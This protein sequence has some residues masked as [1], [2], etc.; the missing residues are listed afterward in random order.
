MDKAIFNEGVCNLYTFTS[1]EAIL[2]EFSVCFGEPHP[3]IDNTV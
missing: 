3:I 1:R 2:I